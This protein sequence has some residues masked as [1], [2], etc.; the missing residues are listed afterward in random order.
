[1]TC[2]GSL[3]RGFLAALLA[4]LRRAVL[5]TGKQHFSGSGTKAD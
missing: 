3:E 2:S 4:S 1:M 5:A